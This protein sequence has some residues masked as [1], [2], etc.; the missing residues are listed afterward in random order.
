MARSMTG[1]GRCQ[2]L[3]DGREI[4]LEIKSVN[5][6]Y[7]EFSSR[8]RGNYGYLEEK[9]KSLVSASVS[10]GKVDLSLYIG[11]VS[12]EDIRVTPN[13]PLA[14][15]YQRAI[16]EIAAELGLKNDLTV[17]SLLR[18]SEIFN[19]EKQ[20][21]DEEKVWA[22]VKEAAEE[23]LA[24]FVA[25]R[26]REGERL[27]HDLDTRL[28][29]ID[30]LVTKVEE[31]SPKSVEDY[32]NKLLSKLGDVLAERGIDEQRILLE[33]AIF[34]E[35]IAV[36]EETVRLRSHL[37]QFHTILSKDEPIGR[38][39]DFL[40]QEINREVNTIGS[41]CQSLEISRI[42]IELKSEI[43]KIREQIQNIE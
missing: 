10:R 29:T 17:G 6:R 21:E 16:A 22:I 14:E 38:K 19:V 32:R 11:G 26:V 3:I 37:S 1:F 30:T 43:E 39:L 41:K 20:P 31:L 13:L 18:F 35:R 12:G 4:T 27:H 5:H 9:L 2:K 7:F 28:A 34:A 25:M 24:G 40:V 33:A 15:G 23:A 42:V 36:A 8:I